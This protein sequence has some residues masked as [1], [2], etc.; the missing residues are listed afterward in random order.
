MLTT[1]HAH[2]HPFRSLLGTWRLVEFRI[3]Y[4]DGEIVYPM[5]SDAEGLMVYT[6]AGFMSGQLMQRGRPRFGAVRSSV[7]ERGIGTAEEIVAAFNGYFAYFGRFEIEVESSRI[8]HHVLACHL[9]DW[10]GRVLER[11]YRFE[12]DEGTLCLALRSAP[13]TIEGRT[14]HNE[15]RFRREPEIEIEGE[16]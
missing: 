16:Q 1:A 12:Q 15:L 5:G 7:A 3:V 10:E 11:F 8:R 14:A 13:L 2:A 9:P 4:V 6:A